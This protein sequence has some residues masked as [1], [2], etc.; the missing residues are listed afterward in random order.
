MHV[1][2]VFDEVLQIKL[3]HR[4]LDEHKASIRAR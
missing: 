3:D 1:E 4:A 2:Y